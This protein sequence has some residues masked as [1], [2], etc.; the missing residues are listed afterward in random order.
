M[1]PMFELPQHDFGIAIAP[2]GESGVM[3]GE[4]ELRF[5]DMTTGE[6]DDVLDLTPWSDSDLDQT[7]RMSSFTP[8]GSRLIVAMPSGRAVV[9][10]VETREVTLP[11][12]P[13]PDGSNGITAARFSPDG[14]M[15]ATQDSQGSI[16]IRDPET[17]E[18]RF[19]LPSGVTTQENLSDG[20]YFSPDSRYLL[21]T[22][23]KQPRLWDVQNRSLVGTFANDPGLTAEGSS[24]P[25]RLNL[26]TL[27]GEHAL[28]WNLN[29][30]EWREIACRAAGRNMTLDEWDLFGPEGEPYRS[31]CPQW[32]SRG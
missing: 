17:L 16:E 23:D 11:H 26:V 12:V 27:V 30:D 19:N 29:T 20:P 31:T 5:V 14:T 21:T 1:K 3:A 7:T 8:D 22:R 18:V 28:V 9:I 15:L 2:D 4:M 32:P 25:E 24:G 10:D 13:D 6:V